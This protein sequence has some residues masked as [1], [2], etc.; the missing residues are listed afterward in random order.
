MLSSNQNT[1]AGIT[2]YDWHSTPIGAAFDLTVVAG[3]SNNPASVRINGSGATYQYGAW[4]LSVTPAKGTNTYTV[5]AAWAG[6]SADTQVVH[7]VRNDTQPPEIGEEALLFPYTWARLEA[8]KATTLR[9]IMYRLKD[10]ADANSVTLTR[11]GVISLA[12]TQ[13]VAV[14]AANIANS[15]SRAWTPPKALASVSNMYVLQFTVRDTSNNST[16]RTFFSSPFFVYDAAPIIGADALVMPGSNTAFVCEQPNAI[17]WNQAK[18]TDAADGTALLITRIAALSAATTG[19]VAA[20]ALDVSNATQTVAWTPAAGLTNAMAAYVL[21]FVVRD[22]AGNS[23]SRVF[24]S[25]PFYVVP[26]PAA[27]VMLLALAGMAAARRAG[28]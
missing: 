24:W 27:L 4:R 12:T 10:E 25:N 26:E 6:G 8:G 20:C 17:T 14:V 1:I 7:Y 28:Q 21:Q 23:T 19:E 5:V 15:G 22:S 11:V 9:W 2:P 3:G 16:N 18:I 13:E